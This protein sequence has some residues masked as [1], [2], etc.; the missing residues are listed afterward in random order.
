M[1]QSCVTA[2]VGQILDTMIGLTRLTPLHRVIVAGGDSMALYL[3]LRQRGFMR[4]T[5]PALCR[6]KWKEHTIGFIAGRDIASRGASAGIEGNLDQISA[7]LAINASLA[8][9]VG[10]RQNGLKNR[11]KLE[12]LGFRVEAGVRCPQGL[13]LSASR[14]GCEQIARAA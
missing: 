14:Q 2:D 10:L 11:S 3:R 8:L 5:T 12:A 6:F 1:P 4:T 9:L 13:V 7:F